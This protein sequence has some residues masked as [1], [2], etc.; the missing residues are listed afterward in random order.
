[1]LQMFRIELTFRKAENSH[2]EKEKG[3]MRVPMDETRPA[4]DLGK[5]WKVRPCIQIGSGETY[6]I[7]HIEGPAIIKS[8]W[9]TC[10]PEASRWMLLRIYWDREEAPS[11]EAPLGDFFCSGWNTPTFV[12][13][14]PINVNPAGDVTAIFPC[15][16][17]K[18][19]GLR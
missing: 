3:A 6:E 7:A 18:A 16:S 15:P 17:G 10:F 19:P 8:I 9:M 14:L 5:G 1:M 11:L 2:G 4:F 13:S 12:A